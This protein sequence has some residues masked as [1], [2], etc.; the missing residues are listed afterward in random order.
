MDRMKA[1]NEAGE[2]RFIS[3]GLNPCV[4]YVKSFHIDDYSNILMFEP[5]WILKGNVT[6]LQRKKLLKRTILRLLIHT[7]MMEVKC[8][9]SKS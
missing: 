8:T 2:F 1:S 6:N 5:H 4:C 9:Q 7:A 3:R